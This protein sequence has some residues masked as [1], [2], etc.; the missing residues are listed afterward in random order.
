MPI[1]PSTDYAAGENGIVK[2]KGSAKNMRRLVKK[3]VGYQKG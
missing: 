3:N 1:K 2:E